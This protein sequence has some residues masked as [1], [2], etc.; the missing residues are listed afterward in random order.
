MS[1]EQIA[2]AQLA[3][4]KWQLW[5]T[6]AAIFL[7]PITGVIFTFWFQARKD[8]AS[9]KH[10]LFLALMSERKSLV[11]SWQRAQA[12]N[13]IDVVFSQNKEIIRLWHKYYSLLSQPPN[14]DRAHTWLELLEAMANDLGYASVKQTDLDK[15]YLPQ[16]HVD[17]WEFQKR[18]ADQ[19]MRVLQNTE[20]FIFEP[21]NPIQKARSDGTDPV[22]N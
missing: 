18:M 5:I 10:K 19:W 21:I 4:A 11:I 1:P 9:E 22:E 3:L 8:K 20:R 6:A 12:L 17:E 7:G 13:T 14:E 16:G 2:L 15:F